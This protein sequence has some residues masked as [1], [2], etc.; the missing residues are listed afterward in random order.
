[1]TTA[2]ETLDRTGTWAIDPTH[3]SID[4]VVR[5]AMVSK[6]RGRFTDFTGTLRLDE[7]DPTK[8]TA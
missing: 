4:F 3:S 6:V 8:S 1:M 5:H 2:T 7:A